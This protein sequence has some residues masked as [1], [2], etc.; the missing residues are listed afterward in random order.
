[1]L[2][3][4]LVSIYGVKV[5]KRSHHFFYRASC[6]RSFTLIELV[7]IIIIVGITAISVAPKFANVLSFTGNNYFDQTLNSLRYAQKFAVAT[8]CHVQVVTTANSVQL[9]LRSGCRSGNFT[10][11][12]QDPSNGNSFVHLAPSGVSIAGV[13]MPIYFDRLGRANQMNGN[14]LNASLMLAGRTINIIAQTGFVYAP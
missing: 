13:N 1:M 4:S 14:L 10:L 5:A 3:Y 11:P 2:S 7:L 6:C 8:G 9:L 12:V